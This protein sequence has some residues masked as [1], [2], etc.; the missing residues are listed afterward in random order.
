M[1]RYGKRRYPSR[2]RPKRSYKT[3][4]RRPRRAIRKAYRKGNIRAGGTLRPELKYFDSFDTGTLGATLAPI[5]NA[6]TSMNSPA[7]GTTALTRIG[8]KI[9]VRSINLRLTF[10][11]PPT[12]ATVLGTTAGNL[13]RVILLIDHQCNGTVPTVG[14][15]LTTTTDTNSFR[16]MQTTAR[17][18]VL[19]DKFIVFNP[20]V[21]IDTPATPDWTVGGI[22]KQCTFY[23][24]T[25]LLC[26][27]DSSSAG[28]IGSQT[29][30]ALLLY[31]FTDTTT[32]AI[33]YD[34]WCRVRFVG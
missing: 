7:Q 27:F 28:S 21:T 4:S 1:P 30:N 22:T 17:F 11:Q 2:R 25:S 12:T 14:D 23:K 6:D 32:I 15:I 8:D 5:M 31:A 18:T 29:N 13:V 26:Q 16:E 20:I 3:M 19:M 9:I 33:N 34:W 24:K 10:R